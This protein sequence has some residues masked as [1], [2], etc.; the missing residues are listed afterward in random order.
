MRLACLYEDHV[1]DGRWFAVEGLSMCARHVACVCTCVLHAMCDEITMCTWMWYV[2]IGCV[3]CTCLWC[4]LYVCCDERCGVCA[5]WCVYSMY[6]GPEAAIRVLPL[7]HSDL[8]SVWEQVLR[9]SCAPAAEPHISKHIEC[10][11]DWPFCLTGKV[12]NHSLEKGVT[13][14]T[15]AAACGSSPFQDGRLARPGPGGG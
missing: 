3:W 11:K 12:S 9:L 1:H 2:C 6:G 13:G 4:V 14:D 10:L 5:V 7:G 8:T 15:E